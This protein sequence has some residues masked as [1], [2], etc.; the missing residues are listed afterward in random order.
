MKNVT[1][2]NPRYGKARGSQ[3]QGSAVPFIASAAHPPTSL[4]KERPDLRR[5][6]DEPLPPQFEE[7]LSKVA[8][9]I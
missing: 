5:P 1:D 7:S 2:K 4:A 9:R 3:A 6:M 8:R